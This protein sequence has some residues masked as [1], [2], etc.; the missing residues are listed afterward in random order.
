MQQQ[1]SE[2]EYLISIIFLNIRK[3]LVI[4]EKKEK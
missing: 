4:A 3:Q 2:S 1:V